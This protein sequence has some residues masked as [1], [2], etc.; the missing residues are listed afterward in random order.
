M[1]CHYTVDEY[2]FTSQSRRQSTR[3]CMIA[4]DHV[5]TD[6]LLHTKFNSNSNK[7]Q[8]K[9]ADF[10]K[11]NKIQIRTKVRQKKTQI[12]HHHRHNCNVYRHVTTCCI[13]IIIIIFLLV[14]RN[15][16]RKEE[17]LRE[18]LRRGL[19]HCRGKAE[20]WTCDDDDDVVMSTS[21]C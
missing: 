3:P 18:E 7:G 4:S 6:R 16:S 8:T 21:G 14:I 9:L 12:Q 20:R 11:L 1:P 15:N 5:S 10:H 19:R 13:I 2:N 17:T